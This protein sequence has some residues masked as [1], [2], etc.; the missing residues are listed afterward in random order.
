MNETWEG[1][2]L[3][4]DDVYN[5]FTSYLSTMKQ[6]TFYLATDDMAVAHISKELDVIGLD[7]ISP[8]TAYQEDILSI[9]TEQENIGDLHIKAML[10]DPTSYSLNSTIIEYFLRSFF[11]V[12]WNEDELSEKL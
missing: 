8:R 11:T 6:S 1:E 5:I 4:E 7:M 3:T 12:L 10:A 9:I 2:Y